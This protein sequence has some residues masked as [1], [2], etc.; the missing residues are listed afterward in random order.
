MTDEQQA[1]P[2]RAWHTDEEFGYHR[3]KA[4]QYS[5]GR[6][7]HDAVLILCRPGETRAAL[8][9]RLQPVLEDSPWGEER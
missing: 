8:L 6:G 9:A 2:V 4:D 1:F 7:T 3:W 5:L